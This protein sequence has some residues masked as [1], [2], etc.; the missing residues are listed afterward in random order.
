MLG[1]LVLGLLLIGRLHPGTGAQV[2]DWRPTRSPA[3][4]AQNEIDDV[5]QM[6]EAQNAR[7]R[8]RGLPERTEEQ[9]QAE[10]DAGRREIADRAA[11]YRASQ[12]RPPEA[13]G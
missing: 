11:R 5:E 7:R 9:V 1:L 4:E 12:G 6:L 2:L 3:V 8:R 10:V 13:R